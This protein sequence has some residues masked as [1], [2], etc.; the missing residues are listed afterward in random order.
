MQESPTNTKEE[1]V[2][3][4]E[5]QKYLDLRAS[6]YAALGQ[7]HLIWMANYKEWVAKYGS[8]A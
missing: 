2:V 3:D 4:Q 1:A 8:N 5:R 7:A 6:G